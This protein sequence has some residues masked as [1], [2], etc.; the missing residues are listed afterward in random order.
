MKYYFFRISDPSSPQYMKP[1]SVYRVG[2]VED[3]LLTER[4]DAKKQMWVN[5]GD[6]LAVGGM[7]GD[8]PYWETTKKEAIEFVKGKYD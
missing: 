4:W 1:V 3:G 7:G 6:I 8:H 2:K 5:D